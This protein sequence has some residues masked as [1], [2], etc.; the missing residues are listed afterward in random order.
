M[1]NRQQNNP[2]NTQSQG[3]KK[4]YTNEL[5]NVLL[6][7]PI[8][9]RMAATEIGFP[10][11]TY[12]VTQLIYDWINQGKAQVVGKIKCDRSK[13]FVQAVTTNPDFFVKPIQGELRFP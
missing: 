5:F 3:T 4:E 11:Q 9:R 13:R 6:R 2:C 10:D 7:E 8:S 12:M 1:K